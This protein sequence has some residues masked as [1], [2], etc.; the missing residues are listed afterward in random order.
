MCHTYRAQLDL[1]PLLD[2]GGYLLVRYEYLALLPQPVTQRVYSWSGLGMV[3]PN[4]VTWIDNNT[5][6]EN[7]DHL[8]EDPGTHRY[9]GRNR[10]RRLGGGGSKSPAGVGIV[11]EYKERG[12]RAGVDVPAPASPSPRNNLRRRGLVSTLFVEDFETLLPPLPPRAGHAHESN[13]STAPAQGGFEPSYGLPRS[14]SSPSATTPEVTGGG[15]A[16]PEE[17]SDG[18]NSRRDGRRKLARSGGSGGKGWCDN[19]KY[20]NDHPFDTK[21]HSQDMVDLWRQQM[22]SED[23]KAVWDACQDSGV[24][25]ELRYSP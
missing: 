12:G 20:S 9:R 1:P 17:K 6:M 24:M 15:A 19:Q 25:A 16:T 14:G 23:I 21:R 10:N 22:P 13:T 5:R 7:C 3:P 8:G 4:L 18:L 11:P 2:D